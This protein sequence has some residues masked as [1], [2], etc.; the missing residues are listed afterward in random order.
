M[1][2]TLYDTGVFGDEPAT[3]S[4]TSAEPEQQP[5]KRKRKAWGQPIP[6]F[7]E[8]IGPRKRAKTAEEKEQ[9]KN[10]RILRNRKA[11]DKS[12]QRQKK[13]VEELENKQ[14]QM[15]RENATLRHLVAQYQS[16]FGD[17]PGFTFPVEAPASNQPAV[18]IEMQEDAKYMPRTPLSFDMTDTPHTPALSYDSPMATSNQQS[19]PL[20]PTLFP[21]QDQP[22]FEH[23]DDF[24][25][26][27]H[28]NETGMTQYP[29]AI[30]CDPQCQPLSKKFQALK[31]NRMF[32]FSLQL[33][34]L[35]TMS[36]IYKDYSTT[37]LSPMSTIFRTLV[38]TLSTPLIDQA[39]LDN[40]F[41]LL[42]TLISMPTS[43]TRPA[44]F[45]M[46]LLSKLLAC[47]PRMAR[48]L[49]AATDRELQRVVSEDSFASDPHSRWTWAS[50]LTMKWSILRLEREHRRV[51][52][53]VVESNGDRCD[54]NMAGVDYGAVKRSSWRW[55]GQ[56]NVGCNGGMDGA[57]SPVQEVH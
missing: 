10:E 57:S 40:H 35:I 44:V 4:T 13:A 26:L 49:M 34:Q 45:R 9:R 51:R 14:T 15:A 24:S 52:L 50:L 17:I 41:S 3:P 20:V 54:R 46:K 43:T 47:S 7:K 25:T 1:E 37:I 27:E 28:F 36:M 2:D 5:N 48:L 31:G 33:I 42:H 18:K 29:A 38:E 21:S 56:E 32:N 23:H 19:P 39:F 12:R 53:V 30:L 55:H 16:R 22:G 11:A 8:V 6:E